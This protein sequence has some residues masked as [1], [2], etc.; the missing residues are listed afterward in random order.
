MDDST[1]PASPNP[2]QNPVPEG[3]PS[4]SAATDQGLKPTRGGGYRVGSALA[5]A[6]KARAGIR[7]GG[8]SA[9][10]EALSDG[11]DI[12]K[13]ALKGAATGGAAGAIR[14]A[15]VGA[16]KSKTGKKVIAGVTAVLVL[17]IGIAVNMV[18]VILPMQNSAASEGSNKIAA[19]SAV[20]K[21]VKDEDTFDT[22]RRAAAANQVPFPALAAL[23]QVQIQNKRT[24][25]PLG[26][27][28]AAAGDDIDAAGADDLSTAADLIADRL[29]RELRD[30]TAGLSSSALDI[31]MLEDVTKDGLRVRVEDK[32]E[33][34]VAAR[35]ESKKAWVEAFKKLPLTG[36][37]DS[38]E[39]AYGLAY[40]W[41]AGDRCRTVPDL[42]HDKAATTGTQRKITLNDTQRGYAKAIVQKSVDLGLPRQAAV[43]AIMTALQES[44][45]RMY[46]NPKVPGSEALAPNK[47]DR[48]VDGYS[49]GLFQQQ[50]N[51]SAY[52]WGTVSQAMDPEFSS[53]S[54]YSRLKGVK[55]WEELGYGKAAQTV[56]VSAH[57]EAYDKWQEAAETIVDDALGSGG[58]S[59]DGAIGKTEEC[60]DSDL[61]AGPGITGDGKYL[62]PVTGAI[63]TPFGWRF[64][65]IHKKWMIHY[66]NDYSRPSGTPIY[67]TAAGTVTKSGSAGAFGNHIRIQHADGVGSSYSHIVNG[68]LL[69]GIGDQVAAGQ[70]IAKVGSTGGS[71][72][73]H[74]HFEMYFD[75]TAVDAQA[76]MAGT[77]RG[78]ANLGPSPG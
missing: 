19:E 17:V 59:S 66:G 26:I 37:A 8:A 40:A 30:A 22:V 49:V 11:V 34:A 23:Y 5:E 33:A 21:A 53:E 74:L 31:G 62:Q 10:E 72:G 14:G 77:V 73:P 7:R 2:Y 46:W 68:G 6:A 20:L 65:P 41:A 42:D 9:G 45:L 75:G 78:A 29:S 57:P 76:F 63:P 56:Q 15:A 39:T 51:G 69:V 25:G 3:A 32:S 55:G 24:A 71:T 67:A 27:D 28:L 1:P 52:S 58:T 18:V 38:A 64:H 61:T 60:D 54:F 4:E 16:L 47:A 50:V 44:T 12:A 35:D 43:I 13:S 48:G 70:M 36:I